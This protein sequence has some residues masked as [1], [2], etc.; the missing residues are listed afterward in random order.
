MTLEVWANVQAITGAAGAPRVLLAAVGPGEVA[1]VAIVFGTAGA[2]LRPLIRSW[3]GQ[4][5]DRDSRPIAP[6]DI[7]AR[8]DRMERGIEAIA[9]EVERISENQRFVTQVLSK[10]EVRMLRQGQDDRAASRSIG[11]A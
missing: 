11:N 10:D 8:L 2:I 5:G 6:R 3:T 9:E 7:E 4:A 1:V